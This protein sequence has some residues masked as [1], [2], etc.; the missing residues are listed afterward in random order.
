M[1]KREL[2]CIGCPL[3]CQINVTLDSGNI[4]S[5]TGN[6]CPRGKAYAEKEVTAPERIVT[7]TV[8]IAGGSLDTHLPVKT[9]S[10]VPKGKIFDI[11][12]VLKGIT[13]KAPVMTG[14]VIVR[15]VCETGV[16]IVA[17]KTIE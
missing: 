15:N 14:D 8:P 13:V 9:A 11:M 3:G 10:A 12:K 4:I 1:E 16:D 6:T 7:S 5:V 2:T 17:S